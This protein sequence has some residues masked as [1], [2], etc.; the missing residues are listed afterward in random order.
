MLNPAPPL[1]PNISETASGIMDSVETMFPG[2]ERGTLIQISKNR[3]KPTNMY[4]LRASEKERA[5]THRT[6]HIG[7][8]D[9]EQA[10]REGKES[11]YRM[12]S[13]FKGWAV[14]IGIQIKPTPHGLQ[15]ELATGLCIYTRTSMSY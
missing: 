2:V 4:R 5:E 3:F 14:Y 1:M 15:G 6:I 11:E 13:F 7:A 8:M 10:E 12:T 9:F